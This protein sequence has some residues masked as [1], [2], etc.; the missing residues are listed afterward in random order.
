[1]DSASGAAQRRRSERIATTVASAGHLRRQLPEAEPPLPASTSSSFGMPVDQQVGLARYVRDMV[2]LAPTMLQRSIPASGAA[3][4]FEGDGDGRHPMSLE[5]APESPQPVQRRGLKRDASYGSAF[6]A[7]EVDSDGLGGSALLLNASTSGPAAKSSRVQQ[8]H[9]ILMWKDVSRTSLIFG[10]GCFCIMSQYALTE[11][12]I[13]PVGLVAYGLLLHL[14]YMFFRSHYAQH[15]GT[16]QPQT[17]AP[18]L[19]EES[20]QRLAARLVAAGNAAAHLHK[21]FFVGDTAMTLKVAVVLWLLAQL[22]TFFSLMT[23]FSAAFVA[24]FIVPKLYVQHREQAE[25]YVKPVLLD[26]WRQWQEF[27]HRRLAAAAAGLTAWCLLGFGT[28]L[29]LGFVLFLCLRLYRER[30]A[31]QVDA[32]IE[33]VRQATHRMS[34]GMRR[35][36]DGWGA[37][38]PVVKVS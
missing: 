19:S 3:A 8:V 38:N 17:E 16:A 11:P 30:H 23:L 37:H 26:V 14:G 4:A 24:A 15:V 35:S 6:D 21:S 7:R 2:G 32:G 1:M 18:W 5:H 28:K 29:F 25:L 34:M 31:E 36:M 9:D 10:G 12:V 22:S 20:A 27:Q 33:Y 13:S